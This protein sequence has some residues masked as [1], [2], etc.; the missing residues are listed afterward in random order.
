MARA[1]H[2]IARIL[3]CTMVFMTAGTT[4][5]AAITANWV[6]L[7]A[8][9]A[10][11]M[12]ME[13]VQLG[14]TSACFQAQG[15]ELAC[16][17]YGQSLSDIPHDAWRIAALFFLLGISFQWI[18]FIVSMLIICSGHLIVF[19]RFASLTAS[20]MVLVGICAFGG[21]LKDLQPE[22]EAI[23]LMQP[24]ID[25]DFFKLGNCALGSSSIVG[26]FGVSLSFLTTIGAFLMLPRS[27]QM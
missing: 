2:T 27:K 10:D 12:D 9:M 8:L 23:A 19:L 6:E 18:I 5:L 13:V 11:R 21:G 17:Q 14:L 1:R 24:C 16:G 22:R 3:W 26:I 25:S 4:T 20:T 7:P 15:A